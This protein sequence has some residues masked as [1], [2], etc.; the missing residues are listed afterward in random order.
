MRRF[1]GEPGFTLIELLLV[2]A[3]LGILLALSLAAVQRVRANSFRTVC[4]NNLRQIGLALYGYHDA[5]GS[6]PP[7]VSYQDG[8]SPY[9]FM[10]CNTRLLPFLEQSALWQQAVEAYAQDPNFFASPP[11]LL[12]T[13]NPRFGCPSDS[14]TLM[15]GMAQ[16]RVPVAFTIYLGVEGIDQYRTGG[17]LFLDS[18]IRLSDVTDGLSNTLMVGERPP[19]TD[20]VAG[21][22]YAGEGQAKD[23]SAD[24]V[25]GVRERNFFYPRTCPRGPS[26]YGPGDL[27]NQCDCLHFWSLHP[28]GGA[29]FLLAD[30]SVHFLAYSADPIMPDLATRAGGEAAQV[31]D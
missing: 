28:G 26:H 25:L 2:L 17:V 11:H 22:W 20:E 24:M 4:T 14:R 1:R 19:S 29:N 9:P 15:V 8:R 13:L 16:G 3:I 30:G 7:G 6:L 21:W 10:S 5:F 18:A 31:P 27:H 12:A 23:G